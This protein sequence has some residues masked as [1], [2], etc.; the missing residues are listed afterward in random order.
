[1]QNFLFIV[2]VILISC[3]LLSPV[4][5][6]IEIE[7][8]YAE[9]TAILVAARQGDIQQV[10]FDLEPFFYP[11]LVIQKNIPFIW[12]IDVDEKNLNYCNDEI[13]IPALTIAKKLEVGENVIEFTPDELGLIEYSCWMNMITSTIVIVDDTRIK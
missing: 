8:T 4:Y 6:D 1:M 11:E 7:D 5:S 12:I 13:I 2:V 10:R 3:S 9:K